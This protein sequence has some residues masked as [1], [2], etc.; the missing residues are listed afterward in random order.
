MWQVSSGIFLGWSLGANDASNVFGT[1]V[2]SKMVKFWTAACLCAVFIILGAYISGQAGMETYSK[3]GK[4][5]TD[6]AFIAAFCAALTVT[7]MTI[8]GLPVSTSQAVVG[9]MMAVAFLDNNANWGGLVKVG[10]CWVGTPIGAMLLSIILYYVLGAL[11]NWLDLSIFMYDKV[12]RW[13]LLA[14]GSYGAYAL[15]ANNVAN[16]TGAFVASGQLTTTQGVLIGGFSIALGVV[17][18]SRTVMM[19]VGKGL[20]KL[21]AFSAL[22][23]VLAEAITVHFYAEVGVPVSTSQAVVGGVLGIGLIRGAQTVNKSTLTKIVFGWIATPIV[24]FGMSYGI[25]LALVK[26]TILTLNKSNL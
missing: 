19:T 22:V 2:A 14:A 16:S 20:V 5:G 1:A 7:I 15:G 21:N 23:V 13:S 9:S 26:L 4:Y 17:T 18:F 3:L 25:S 12:L 10:L 24:S 8:W 11:F 6:F